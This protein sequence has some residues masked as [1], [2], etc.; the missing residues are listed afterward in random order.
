MRADLHRVIAAC[1]TVLPLGVFSQ[2]SLKQYFYYSSHNETRAFQC[3]E[4]KQSKQKVFAEREVMAV[5][6]GKDTIT[7]F[8]YIKNADGKYLVKNGEGYF[9]G[10][11][12]II[13]WP[14][15]SAGVNYRDYTEALM[16]QQKLND[17]VKEYLR[18]VKDFTYFDNAA[19]FSKLTDNNALTEPLLV[20]TFN[21]E[22]GEIHNGLR[23]GTWIGFGY[24]GKKDTLI[25][26]TAADTSKLLQAPPVFIDDVYT[27]DPKKFSNYSI[28]NY[29]KGRREGA[30]MYK[31]ETHYLRG[32]YKEGKREGEWTWVPWQERELNRGPYSA[33]IGMRF[34]YKDG[35]LEGPLTIYHVKTGKK[36]AAFVFLKG[37]FEG[38]LY[39]TNI[40]N[41]DYAYFKG[42]FDEKGMKDFGFLTP[43]GDAVPINLLRRNMRFHRAAIEEPAKY[44]YAW[45][46]QGNITRLEK[47]DKD[48][49]GVT[50]QRYPGYITRSIKEGARNYYLTLTYSGDTTKFSEY[51]ANKPTGT[52]FSKDVNGNV[53]YESHT[54][55][56]SRYY[57]RKTAQGQITYRDGN[58]YAIEPGGAII[59][60]NNYQKQRREYKKGKETSLEIYKGEF[61]YLMSYIDSSGNEMIKDGF[62]Y[63]TGRKATP[64]SIRYY[65]GGVSVS[66]MRYE[67]T[68]DPSLET[69]LTYSVK[70]SIKELSPGLYEINYKLETPYM[71]GRAAVMDTF[72]FPVTIVK[73][74]TPPYR[75]VYWNTSKKDT[76]KLELFIDDKAKEHGSVDEIVWIR[77]KPGLTSGAVRGSFYFTLDRKPRKMRTGATLSLKALLAQ[78]ALKM[79]ITNGLIDHEDDNSFIP[80][81]VLQETKAGGFTVTREVNQWFN[82]GKNNYFRITITPPDTMKGAHEIYYRE[83]LNT[84]RRK[85]ELNFIP[86][87]DSYDY[88]KGEVLSFRL[89]DKKRSEQNKFALNKER[90]VSFYVMPEE[91]MEL[92]AEGSLV[93]DGKEYPIGKYIS[94][95]YN[96]LFRRIYKIGK[97]EYEQLLRTYEPDIQK[98]RKR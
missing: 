30:W 58:G 10:D 44:E 70:R 8:N 14:A 46:E 55:G 34:N 54:N 3:F 67:I 94:N 95:E 84:A 37:K 12:R 26:L 15:R 76:R 59:Y 66:R 69:K 96:P 56:K 87:N 24:N 7:H 98:Y 21:Y 13:S 19:W 71:A 6:D 57:L 90:E 22:A 42:S 47:K 68:K 86:D 91:E 89:F 20:Y 50:M 79:D 60:W 48:G 40:I 27:K 80:N 39:L 9:C 61:P 92:I 65:S 31:T 4:K 5:A 18:S 81:R 16:K 75:D 97:E 25:R 64:D 72:P 77:T 45:D 1:L 74:S 2:A 17:E 63:V 49:N 32:V 38:P 29:S 85:V 28:G 82:E 78:P 23:E 33:P 52:W 35:K 62:G 51:T 41:S 83:K 36:L 11:K 43:L 88:N 93:V 73:V 53:D